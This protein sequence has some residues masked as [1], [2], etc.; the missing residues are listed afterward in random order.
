MPKGTATAI[1]R[2]MMQLALAEARKGYEEGGVP[3]GA[4][5]VESDTLLSIGRNR[6]VQDGNPIAH[7]EI[8]CLRRLGRR[9]NYKG[10]TLYTTVSPCM[11][12]AG[13]IVQF[14]IPRVIVGEAKSFGGNIEFLE[15][16]DVSV[17]LLDDPDCI[18][19]TELFI[20]EQPDLWKEDSAE[21]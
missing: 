17:V 11:M 6:R 1:D 10:L 8:D 9:K 19:L 14:G 16:S 18:A 2:K 21:E 20:R 15:R 13:A 7:A 3:V 5:I 12:C 4:A